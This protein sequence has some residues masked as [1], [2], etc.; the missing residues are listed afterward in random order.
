M[1]TL[2]R[3]DA[4]ALRPML[5]KHAAVRMR[6]RG[7]SSRAVDAALTYGRQIRARGATYCVVGHKEVQNY[8][9][10]GIDLSEAEG[11]QVLLSQDGAVVT[12]YR[13]HDLH[14]IKVTPRRRR[15]GVSR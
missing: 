10:F 2:P 5:T 11:V 14:A 8:A 4:N 7:V 12:V 9:R 6:Q 3:P 1:Q 13:S 15:C